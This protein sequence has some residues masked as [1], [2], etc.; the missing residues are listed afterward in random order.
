ME[1][2][3]LN[4]KKQ[5]LEIEKAVL[6]NDKS[7]KEENLVVLKKDIEKKFGTSNPEELVKIKADLEKQIEEKTQEYNELSLNS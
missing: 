5:K 2:E 7:Q 4:A 3:E 1:L 6:D